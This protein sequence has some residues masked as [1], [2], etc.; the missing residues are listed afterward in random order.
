MPALSYLIC[1]T[2]RTGSYLLCEALRCTGIAGN[3]NEYFSG[4]YQQYWAPQWGTRGYPAFLRRATRVGTTANGVFGVKVH[5]MQFEHFVRQVAEKPTV[6][7]AK[8]RALLERWF[9]DPRYVWL[10]RSNRLRQAISYARA[11]QTKIWWDA[12][13]APGPYDTPRPEA[14]AFNRDLIERSLVQMKHWDSKWGRYF[15]AHGLDP[16]VLTYEDLVRDTEGALRQVIA[17][18]GLERPRDFELPPSQFRRQADAITEE[19]LARYK[20]ESSSNGRAMG[21]GG[22]PKRALRVGS[23]T[24]SAAEL[25]AFLSTRRW[26]VCTTPFRHLRAER[27]FGPELYEWMATD[28]RDRLANG[29]FARDLPGYDASALTITAENAGAFS[30]F[31][32]PGWRDLIAAVLAP[33]STRELNLSLHHHAVGSLSGLP[34]NDLNPGYFIDDDG[35]EDII[36]ADPA[37]CSYR[38]GKTPEQRPAVERVRSV[39]VIYY[40]ANPDGYPGWGGATGLYARGSDPVDRPIA[41]VPP[42]NNSLVAFECTPFS[43]HSFMTNPRFERNCMVMWLHRTKQEAVRR[44]GAHSIVGW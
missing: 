23:E 41:A 20:A 21:A 42:I 28:F 11:V 31:A 15:D 8:R 2:P 17:H 32:S 26:W 7:I 18:L 5:A 27:V 6:P 14:L 24:R 38:S 30:I 33:D 10:R 16:L 22:K 44:W 34:H 3:P 39:A 35:R 19:W 40:V 36:V 37:V 9:P 25:A 43:F 1:T 4:G 12:D 13:E 29:R